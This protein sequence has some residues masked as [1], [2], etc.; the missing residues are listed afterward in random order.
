M[1]FSQWSNAS[2]ITL[3]LKE[4]ES[5]K[6]KTS[7]SFVSSCIISECKDFQSQKLTFLLHFNRAKIKETMIHG[8][9]S[10][11]VHV[12]QVFEHI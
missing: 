9:E 7:D 12:L 11:Q 3:R 5:G 4:P 1:S 10:V 6:Q 2:Y 8:D